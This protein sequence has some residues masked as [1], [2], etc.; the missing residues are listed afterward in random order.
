MDSAPPDF[1]DSTSRR[2]NLRASNA[3][4]ISHS[5][6]AVD[7]PDSLESGPLDS[8]GPESEGDSSLA[9]HT[10]VAS[11][12]F[13]QEV[14]ENSQSSNPAMQTALSSLHEIVS[15]VNIYSSS[16]GATFR[17]AKALPPG[18]LSEL[19]MPPMQAVLAALHG[20]KG[21]S[22]LHSSVICC[23]RSIE[24]FTELCLKVYFTYGN[25]SQA[26]FIIVNVGLYYIF[27]ECSFINS[28]DATRNE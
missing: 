26:D 6:H 24:S 17:N 15:Q 18:G 9:A 3:S 2:G 13:I 10:A 27:L 11:E 28:D 21:L 4:T 22:Q 25:F 8:Q 7:A 5:E 14:Q 19:P 12:L 16:Q 1:D 20:R 23:F